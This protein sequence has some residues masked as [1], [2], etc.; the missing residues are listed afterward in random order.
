MGWRRNSREGRVRDGDSESDGLLAK[1]SRGSAADY[2]EDGRGRWK[3]TV[4][5]SARSARS[6]GEPNRYWG[7]GLERCRFAEVVVR[8]IVFTL[9][10]ARVIWKTIVFDE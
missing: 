7:D 1:G 6:E 9:L 10:T 8:H 4:R 5:K 2:G 3:G